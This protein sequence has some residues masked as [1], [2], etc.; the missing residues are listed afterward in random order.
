M[1]KGTECGVGLEDFGDLETDDQ[2]Q[3]YEI[4]SEKRTL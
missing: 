4:V 3:A 1:G 2:I